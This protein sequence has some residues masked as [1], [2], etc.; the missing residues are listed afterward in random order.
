[1]A[2]KVILIGTSRLL[3]ECANIVD[4]FY[5][6]S[7]DVEVLDFSD[8]GIAGRASKQ[9]RVVLCDKKI[10]AWRHLE[11]VNED[12]FVL[13]I[14]NPYIIPASLCSS[15]K[16]TMVNLHHAL[17]PAHPGRN[18]EAWTIYEEDAQGGITWHYI[19]AGID[20]GAIILQASIPIPDDM[21]SLKLLQKASKLITSTLP[22]LLPFENLPAPESLP[23]PKHDVLPKALD[24]IPNGGLLDTEWPMHKMSAFLRAMDYGFLNTLGVPRVELEGIQFEVIRYKVERGDFAMGKKLSFTPDD[25]KA[26]ALYNVSDERTKITMKLKE[27]QPATK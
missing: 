1:M 14:N 15:N 8:G 18:A 20:T 13:S 23:T 10:D 12:A 26:D 19:D 24:D 17:L 21:T 7:H 2:H 6:D 9:Q 3:Y 5:G 16:L 4:S 22:E 11:A 25:Q 27:F